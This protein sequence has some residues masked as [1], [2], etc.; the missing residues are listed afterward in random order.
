[1]SSMDI[2]GLDVS[3]RV[4]AR[5]IPMTAVANVAR[6]LLL[7]SG[8]VDATDHDVSMSI[9]LPGPG[10]WTVVKAEDQPDRPDVGRHAD[11]HRRGHH[12]RQRQR[13]DDHVVPVQQRRS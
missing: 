2:P 11:H 3:T 1:M 7:I 10:R 8:A 6:K 13:H 4:R 9:A 12:V 5:D